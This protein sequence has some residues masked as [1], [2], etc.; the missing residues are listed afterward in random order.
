[1]LLLHPT[2]R[3]K[4]QMTTFTYLH[5]QNANLPVSDTGAAMV[6]D[7]GSFSTSSCSNSGM[8]LQHQRSTR[9]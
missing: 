1:M 6:D 5:Q 3:D 9:E 2:Y 8:T 4:L 7:Q